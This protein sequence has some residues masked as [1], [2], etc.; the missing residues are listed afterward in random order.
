MVPP[1]VGPATAPPGRNV[2]VLGARRSRN[3]FWMLLMPDVPHL[4][5]RPGAGYCPG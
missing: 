4:A 2:R 1:A 3:P 5:A